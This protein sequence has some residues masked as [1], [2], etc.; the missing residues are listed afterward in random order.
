MANIYDEAVLDAKKI[1]EAAEVAARNKVMESITPQIREMINNR[2][3]SEQEE[4]TDDDSEDDLGFDFDAVMDGMPETNEEEFSTALNTT[5]DR[6][7]PVSVFANGDVNI[8]VEDEDDEYE[9]DLITDNS[10]VETFSYL[11]KQDFVANP[12][13]AN[14][15][16]S[17]SERVKKLK[18]VVSVVRESRLNKRQMQRLEI[19]FIGCVKEAFSLRSDLEQSGRGSQHLVKKLNS[20]IMEMREMSSKYK[21][22]I[23]D[24]LFEADAAK[25]K[26]RK[27][28]KEQDENEDEMMKEQDENEDEDVDVEVD[29][30]AGDDEEFELEDDGADEASAVDVSA[31]SQALRDL[32][33]ALGLNLEIQEDGEEGEDDGMDDMDDMED[34]DMDM[35]DEETVDEVYE[36]D[37]S[38]LRRELSKMRESRSRKPQASA[39]ARRRRIRENGA[40]EMVDQFGGATIIGDVLEIDEETLIN[41]LADELG[42]VK[43][44]RRRRAATG[45]RRVAS[46]Q[47]IK[48]AAV[49]KNATVQLKKQLVEMNLF[50]AKLLYANKLLQNKNLNVKQQRAIVEALDNAKTLIEAKLL[51][52]SLS[53]SLAQKGH[54]GK[55]LSESTR[56]TLGSSSRSTRSAQP[57]NSGDDTDRWA[58]L[59]GISK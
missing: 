57:A 45:S 47:A 30:D 14:R 23:F 13:L 51:Y 46:N 12:S 49:Y 29:D 55:N 53:G 59:A 28:I 37:E 48:E 5:T 32:G 35:G 50:N 26:A 39:A 27:M 16:K 44:S 34:T 38:V 3:L 33:S 6:M 2:I 40:V 4:F 8:A 18:D 41:V 10:I 25:D 21:K 19:G 42:S 22:N 24:F 15:V 52:K 9:N 58:V 1:R 11:V 56:R 20:T 17:L 43:E 31:A 36:I 54:S 7:S